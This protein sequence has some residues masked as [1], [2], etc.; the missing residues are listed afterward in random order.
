[1]KKRNLAKSSAS[2]ANEAKAIPLNKQVQRCNDGNTCHHD[3]KC[4]SSN[5]LCDKQT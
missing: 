2:F 1:M 4:N 3:G 5:K